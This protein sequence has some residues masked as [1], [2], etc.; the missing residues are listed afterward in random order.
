MSASPT[1][2]FGRAGARPLVLHMRLRGITGHWDPAL[3]DL[4]AAEREVVVFDNRGTDFSTGGP[5]ST[6]EGLVDGSLAFTGAWAGG[7]RCPGRV[8][9]RHRRPGR[10]PDRA[11][12]GEPAGGGRQFARRC[13]RPAGVVDAAREVNEFLGR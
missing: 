6:M 7:H 13:A 3:L 8:H 9:G 10:G 2:A 5:P 11:R 12:S 1:A 4:L